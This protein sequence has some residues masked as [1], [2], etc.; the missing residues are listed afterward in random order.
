MDPIFFDSWNSLFRTI[1]IGVLGYTGIVLLLR[2]SGKR[3]LSKMNMFDFIVTIALGSTLATMLL[4]QSTTLAQGLAAVATLIGLQF[5]VTWLSVRFG[6]FSDLVKAEPQLLFSNGAYLTAAM[7]RTRVNK[8][9]LHAAI[10]SAAVGSADDVAAMVLET[11]GT[12]SVIPKARLGDGNA[13][14]PQKER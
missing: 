2:I 5:A 11:D 12:I 1:V 4:S 8:A 9:E 10:R 3:T 13:L 6:A 14:P 7:R